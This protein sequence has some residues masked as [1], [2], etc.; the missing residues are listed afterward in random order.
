[1]ISDINLLVVKNKVSTKRKK[2][3]I[4]IRIIA[5]LSLAG[6]GLFSGL[7]Y[8]LNGIIYPVSLK[9]EEESL[10]KSLNDKRDIQV[11]LAVI[12]N[13]LSSIS[14]IMGTKTGKTS[15]QKG[16]SQAKERKDYSRIITKFAESIPEGVV[17]D[18]LKIDKENV[19]LAFS[20]RSLVPINTVIDNLVGLGKENI[21]SLLTLDSLSLNQASGVYALSLKA[22]L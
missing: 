9:Q 22:T 12:N 21:I 6:L 15:N 19:I 17:M 18:I 7:A 1:M 10:L 11:K 20:S 5:V 14:E 4:I 13:R 3:L 8:Y 16:K 2:G